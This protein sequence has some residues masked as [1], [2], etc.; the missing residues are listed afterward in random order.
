MNKT[1]LIN[2]EKKL[3][4]IQNLEENTFY[5]CRYIKRKYQT[6]INYYFTILKSL[7]E[8]RYVFD[9]IFSVLNDC[10][11]SVRHF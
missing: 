10:N 5:L 1:K 8:H 6:H 7:K 2:Y 3:I 9:H 11:A 4:K